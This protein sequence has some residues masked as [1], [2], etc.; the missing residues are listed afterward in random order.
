[1]VGESRAS[2]VG[3]LARLAILRDTMRPQSEHLLEA[4]RLAFAA[5]RIPLSE[6]LDAQK[7]QLQTEVDIARTTGDADIAWAALE[8]AV[9]SDLRPAFPIASPPNG[10]KE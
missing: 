10:G 4:T 6:V 1:M 2:L 8:A 3:A 9:G 7:M 5:G